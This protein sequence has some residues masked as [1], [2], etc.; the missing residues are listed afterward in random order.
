MEEKKNKLAKKKTPNKKKTKYEKGDYVVYPD[1]TRSNTYTP[2][3]YSMI[4]SDCRVPH[5]VTL[6]EQGKRISLVYFLSG[7]EGGNRRYTL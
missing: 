5:E 4:V 1:K 7:H 6:V 2:S 3:R